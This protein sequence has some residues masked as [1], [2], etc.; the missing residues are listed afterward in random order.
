MW[1]FVEVGMANILTT[2]WYNCVNHVLEEEH[3]MWEI[4]N[5]IKVVVD[6]LIINPNDE[7]LY[8]MFSFVIYS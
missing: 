6:N 8:K 3:N 4:D 1:K 7:T 5:C 2:K